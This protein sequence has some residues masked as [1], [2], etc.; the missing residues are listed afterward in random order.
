MEKA[1]ETKPTF[2]QPVDM[3]NASGIASSPGI[4]PEMPVSPQAGGG[5]CTTCADGTGLSSNGAETANFVF[6][7]GTV[8][9]RFPSLGVEKEVAQVTGQTDTAGLTDRQALRAMLSE[10]SNRYLARRMCYV[11]TIEGIETYILQPHDPADIDLLV[12]AVRPIPQPTDIDVVIGVRGPIAPPDLCNGL[13]VPIVIFDQLYSFDTDSLVKAIP[14][15]EEIAAEKFEPTAME[16]LTRIMQLAD[17]AGSTDEHR[18]VNYLA[19]RNPAIY[20]TVADLHGRNFSL[21]AVEVRPSRLSST[22]KIVDV[23]FAFTNR[24]TD[25]AEKYFVRVDVTE[26]FPFMVTKMSPFYER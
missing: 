20:A 10:R 9:P 4:R 5:Q 1:Q 8:E 13:M 3:N 25:V 19:V 18:A 12:E 22:R 11:L 16:L 24:Q 7:L 17:N 26:E 21:T 15:P 2:N 23:I 14:R 6:A